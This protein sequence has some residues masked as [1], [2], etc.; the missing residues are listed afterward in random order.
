[1]SHKFCVAPMIDVTN[2]HCRFFFR[3]FSK[4]SRLYTEMIVADA[5]THG[6]KD[7]Y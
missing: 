7:F 6:D 3:K 1:M 5:I 4:Y 2:R